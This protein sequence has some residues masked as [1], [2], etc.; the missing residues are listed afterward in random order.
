MVKRTQNLW[1]IPSTLSLRKRHS[2]SISFCVDEVDGNSEAE[3]GEFD[4]RVREGVE[5][6]MIGRILE[7]GSGLQSVSKDPALA[8]IYR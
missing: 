4:E 8:V 6:Y 7:I 2:S 5:P 3:Y 1:F